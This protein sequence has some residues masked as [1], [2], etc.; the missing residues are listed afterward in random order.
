MAKRILAD[1]DR[2]WAHEA[3][4]DIRPARASDHGDICKLFVAACSSLQW[5]MPPAAYMVYVTDLLDLETRLGVSQLLLGEFRGHPVGTIACES[6]VAPG[7]PPWPSTFA[8]IRGLAVAPE[9]RGQGVASALLEE[10][11]GRAKG[12]GA[13]AI[14]VHAADF[15]TATIGFYQ[16]FGF[17]R[18]PA[19]DYDAFK[20][21]GDGTDH[22]PLRAF[23]ARLR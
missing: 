15:M 19:F 9:A 10:C 7:R 17:E 1:L 14:G 23:V 13:S 3:P 22:L 12:L 11:M 4:F 21:Y 18:A 20:D 6:A 2:D 16:R 8:G 5:S